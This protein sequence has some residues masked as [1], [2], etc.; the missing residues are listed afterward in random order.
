M[1]SYYK[2]LVGAFSLEI[3][4]DTITDADFL[5]QGDALI[6][7]N[8]HVNPDELDEQKW[9]KFYVE[10]I[11]LEQIRLKNMGDLLVSIFGGNKH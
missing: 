3:D 8:L 1:R 7:S 11:W 9:S 4:S 5:L 2:K 6:R 10:A